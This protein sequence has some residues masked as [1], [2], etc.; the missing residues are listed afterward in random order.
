M[1]APAQADTP[2]EVH[3]VLS[4]DDLRVEL[5]G[6][7]DAPEDVALSFARV[8]PRGRPDQLGCERWTTDIGGRHTRWFAGGHRRARAAMTLD[9]ERLGSM[10]ATEALRAIV[11][12]TAEGHA[13]PATFTVCGRSYEL[14]PAHREMLAEFLGRFATLVRPPEPVDTTPAPTPAPSA[15]QAEGTNTAQPEAIPTPQTP[16]TNAPA[17]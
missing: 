4:L 17:P 12:P 14:T 13:V 1:H 11:T 2:T 16:A 7:A 9:A 15:P 6:R 8:V 5:T 3:G 10:L